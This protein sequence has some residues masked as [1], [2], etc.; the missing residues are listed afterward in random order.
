MSNLA[1]DYLRVIGEYSH[2][3]SL[4][5]YHEQG[6]MVECRK[7]SRRIEEE[8][9]EIVVEIER[10]LLLNG[11]AAHKERHIDHSQFFGTSMSVLV[12]HL[13]AT[14]PLLAK[15][16]PKL[17][18]TTLAHLF[19]PPN[20]ASPSAPKYKSILHARPYQPR[21][22]DFVS[23]RRTHFCHAQVRILCELFSYFSASIYSCDNKHKVSI[24]V[25][26]VNRLNRARKW[27]LDGDAPKF[28]IHDYPKPFHIVPSGYLSLKWSG[29]H[30]P[31]A[32]ELD[33]YSRA[34]VSFPRTGQLYIFNRADHF[35]KST[36]ASHLQDLKVVI[37]LDSG[38][39]DCL[40]VVDH[41][42]DYSWKGNL[43]N[44]LQYFCLWRDLK[45]QNLG[46]CSFPVF[47]FSIHRNLWIRS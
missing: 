38:T 7:K 37:Q 22:D 24:G 21:N 46:S 36:M 6:T 45:L 42:P 3:E 40:L 27:F 15:S 44:L 25:S 35:F 16:H 26:A 13:L 18:P 10:I 9:P 30:E 29:P 1:E 41:G 17:A 33:Q 28:P 23:S 32:Q 5:V 34:H 39:K 12:E 31:R 43:T 8:F 14:F 4:P 2:D 20:E 19:V 11:Y 47:L